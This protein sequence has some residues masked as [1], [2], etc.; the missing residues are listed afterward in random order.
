MAYAHFKSIYIIYGFRRGVLLINSGLM[1]TNINLLMKSF[2]HVFLMTL[3]T[4]SYRLYEF[5]LGARD[6]RKFHISLFYV[7]NKLLVDA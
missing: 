5:I 1:E 7:I 2:F 6:T 4:S 3:W